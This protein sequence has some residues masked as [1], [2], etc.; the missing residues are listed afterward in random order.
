MTNYWFI[1]L[2]A[3]PTASS[4]WHNLRSA[5]SEPPSEYAEA[6]PMHMPEFKIGTL[7]LLIVASENLQKTDLKIEAVVNKLV[8]ALRG[9]LKGES[10]ASEDKPPHLTINSKSIDHFIKSFAWNSSKYRSDRPLKEIID[11]I[12]QEVQQMETSTRA[13]LQQHQQLKGTVTS[14]ERK[15]V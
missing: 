3:T 12:A 14:L 13:R 8:D 15:T 7:D 9:L 1:S 2:P 10:R 5:V 6:V 4:A 11:A